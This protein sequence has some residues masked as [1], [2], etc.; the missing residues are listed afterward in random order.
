MTIENNYLWEWLKDQHLFPPSHTRTCYLNRNHS[1]HCGEEGCNSL[2]LCREDKHWT[3]WDYTLLSQ[4][5]LN[6]LTLFLP[7]ERDLELLYSLVHYDRSYSKY[8]SSRIRLR[9]SYKSFLDMTVKLHSKPIGLLK[10]N[11]VHSCI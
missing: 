4:G 8:C 11:I 3:N 7:L 1:T 6:I 9:T 5:I 10:I 2:A